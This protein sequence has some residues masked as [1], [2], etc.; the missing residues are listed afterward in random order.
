MYIDPSNSCSSKQAFTLPGITT[1]IAVPAKKRFP[2]T[3]S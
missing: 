3:D 1:G 2:E